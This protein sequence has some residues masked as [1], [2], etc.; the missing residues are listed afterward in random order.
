[1]ALF[2]SSIQAKELL[3]SDEEQVF[4]KEHPVLRVQNERSWAPIDF[5]ENAKAKG[6]AVDYLSLLAKK[7]GFTLKFLPGRSWSSYLRMLESKQLDL[8]SSIKRTP[9]RQNYMNFT[10]SPIIELYNG[11]LQTKENSFH[12]MKDLE[13]KRVAVVHGYY[14][15]ELLQ[16]HYPNIRLVR[17]K[18]T[19]EAMHLV[20]ENK[21]DAT[22]EYHSVLQYNITR[23]LFTDL[24]SIPLAKNEHFTS[25]K[26]FIGI[27]DDWPLLKSI[28][29]KSMKSLTQKQTHELREKWLAK[30]QNKFIKLD[31][32]ERDY[33]ND[34]KEI[35]YCSDP[36]WLPV[37][38]IEA[39]KHIGI[40]ADYLENISKNMGVKFRLVPTM[41]WNESLE[42]LKSK[43]CDF[44]SSVIQTKDRQSYMN[45][46]SSYLEMSLVITTKSDTFF[47]NSLKNIKGKR[48]AIVDNYAYKVMLKRDY[49]HVELVMVENIYEGLK[50]VEDGSIYAYVDTL[51]AT[52]DQLRMNSF[53]DLKISGKIEEEVSLS[54]GTRKD[55]FLLFDILEKGLASISDEQKKDIYDQW[56]YV[57]IDK[58]DYTL[59]WKGLA[60]ISILLLFFSY[61]YKLTINYNTQLLNINQ[62]LEKL[63]IQLEEL[64]QTDQL[65]KL[66]N[67]RHLDS[68]LN[69]ELK[70][71]LRYESD[72][73]IILLDIDFFKS[74]NDT[75]GHPKGDEVLMAMAKILKDNT[76]EVDTVGRWG[77]EEFLIILS[78][79]DIAHATSTCEKLRTKINEHD[80]GLERQ[81]TASYGITQFN[82]QDDDESSL[83]SRADANL[84][85]AK[86][87]GRDK[88][89]VS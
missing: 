66:S 87:N 80:F 15:E 28:L 11:I 65:T 2:F 38:K 77:G 12:S 81:L 56:V 41:S 57:A 49:P 40:S 24:H 23:Y 1:L 4:I 22:I 16:L 18:D 46:T 34:K 6:Y 43:R 54:F 78:Q 21:A 33:L 8:I 75:Y 9:Q 71:A 17:A 47:I 36:N 59:V 42:F 20:L 10:Q 79:V 69:H 53:S 64:S 32:E 13:G 51:E 58:T 70:R 55:D 72:L 60:F 63:N 82:L 31:K 67:R 74:I 85:E 73:C 5:R 30:L 39:N 19:L 48:I 7:A 14:Q 27:R 76:R 68:T 86:E 88:I 26:Q 44:L 29:D 37:E 50:K 35:T 25:A 84:Y 83:L 61:R 3:L 45:F 89:I 62:E 52:S